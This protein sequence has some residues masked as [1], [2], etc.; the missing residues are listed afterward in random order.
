M[1]ARAFF[2]KGEADD[3]ATSAVDRPAS[4]TMQDRAV[5]FEVPELG[6]IMFTADAALETA[7]RLMDAGLAAKRQS[8][9]RT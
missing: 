3:V 4:A 7:H 9:V 6:K 1:A 5:A 8:S 2:Q